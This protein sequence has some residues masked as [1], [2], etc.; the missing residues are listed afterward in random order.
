MLN[1]LTRKEHLSDRSILAAKGIYYSDTEP[2]KHPDSKVAK[3]KKI[4]DI[5]RN[6]KTEVLRSKDKLGKVLDSRDKIM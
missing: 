4:D 5:S 6:L 1:V 3:W 2:I